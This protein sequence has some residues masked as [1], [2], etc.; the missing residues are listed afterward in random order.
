[1]NEHIEHIIKIVIAFI[2]GACL[3]LER[4]YSNKAA[5]LRTLILICVGST[6]FAIIS[7][8]Y[9]LTGDRIAST[10]V[11]GIGFLGAGVI[12]KTDASIHGITTAAT[13]W[14]AAALGMCIATGDYVLSST[15]LVLTMATLVLMDKFEGAVNTII[16]ART[17][18][19]TVTNTKDLEEINT[20]LQNRKLKY[21]RNKVYK[22]N[23]LV[24]ASYKIICGRN[25]HKELEIS[26]ADAL[27]IHSFDV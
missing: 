21:S 15:V 7:H 5:G 23:N 17:Y 24:K 14:I 10:I 22:E 25:K 13:I 11:T 20:L 2:T 12:F 8:D 6:L 27:Y 19:I 9:F 26:F 3:G 16:Q 1:M 18:F 4:E